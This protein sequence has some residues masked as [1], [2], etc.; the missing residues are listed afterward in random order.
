[1]DMRNF[2][3]L[4]IIVGLLLVNIISA[5]MP[6]AANHAAVFLPAFD[7]PAVY[8]ADERDEK[9][10]YGGI[11]NG[12]Y[13]EKKTVSSKEEALKILRDYFAKKDVKIGEIT[14]REFY[15]EAEIRDRNNKVIDRVIVDKRTGRIRSVY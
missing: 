10:P 1:M 5:D 2:C 13:G 6:I 7:I 15:Y 4:I 14:E 9:Y 11:K 12:G 8:A 3:G